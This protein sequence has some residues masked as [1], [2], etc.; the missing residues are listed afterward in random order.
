M[1]KLFGYLSL[2]TFQPI[3]KYQ[4]FFTRWRHGLDK[5]P[6][7]NKTRIE[8]LNQSIL[9]FTSL[10]QLIGPFLASF[11]LFLSFQL[12]I[13]IVITMTWFEPWIFGIGSSCSTKWATTTAQT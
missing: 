5:Q 12:T 13:L 1:V 9:G 6:N 8:N 10:K 4:L 11:S 3:I 2:V 7:Q